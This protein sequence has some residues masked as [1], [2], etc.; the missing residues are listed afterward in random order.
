MAK[1]IDITDK[2]CFDENPKMIIAGEE[3]EVNADAEAMI[4]LMSVFR[5]GINDM[6]AIGEALSLIFGEKDL[7]KIGSIK[8]NGKKLS[9]RSLMNIIEEATN[10]IM[11]E[12]EPGEQ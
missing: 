1:T 12:S 3:I 4:R 11:G 10:L 8:K 5:N 9:A 7:K 6:A 2:L